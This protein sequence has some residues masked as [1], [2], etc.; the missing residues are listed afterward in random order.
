MGVISSTVL[1]TAEAWH[2][3]RHVTEFLEGLKNR[4]VDREGIPFSL[5][6]SNSLIISTNS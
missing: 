3:S 4:E 5:W 6:Y 1:S 2:S